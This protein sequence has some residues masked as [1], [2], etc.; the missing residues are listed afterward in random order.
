VLSPDVIKIV[1]IIPLILKKSPNHMPK[2]KKSFNFEDSI[3]ELETL[4]SD[5][6]EGELSLEESLAAFE[7]G[8]KLTR[9]CQQH[10]NEAEQK[11]SLLIGDEEELELVDF[12]DDEED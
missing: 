7:K 3:E 1:K 11:V 6:E 9:E 2:Q 4:V 10:L 8:I 5:L 12:E